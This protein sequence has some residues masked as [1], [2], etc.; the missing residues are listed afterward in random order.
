MLH[1]DSQ[2]RINA[3]ARFAPGVIEGPLLRKPV[4]FNALPLAV[5]GAFTIG[6]AIVNQNVKRVGLLIMN[7]GTGNVYISTDQRVNTFDWIILPG[8]ALSF[9]GTDMPTAPMNSIFAVADAGHDIRVMETV[10]A[11]LTGT[12]FA[13]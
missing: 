12:E 11:P 6:P 13:A 2:V 5:A 1:G 4:R 7:V 9:P 8:N 3:Q 10:L